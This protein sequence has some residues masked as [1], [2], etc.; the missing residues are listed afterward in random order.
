M[1]ELFCGCSAFAV[2]GVFQKTLNL[3]FNLRVKPFFLR[4]QCSMF[5]YIFVKNHINQ[6]HGVTP[7]KQLLFGDFLRQRLDNTIPESLF[8]GLAVLF[9]TA[10]FLFGIFAMKTG[11]LI[12]RIAAAHIIAEAGQIGFVV[13]Q[14][15]NAQPFA[16]AVNLPVFDNFMIKGGV[17]FYNVPKRRKK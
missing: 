12:N 2:V 1:Q 9:L 17:G 14:R 7:F 15:F 10:V 3:I 4:R 11:K 13:N 8:R 16:V 5:C 6:F